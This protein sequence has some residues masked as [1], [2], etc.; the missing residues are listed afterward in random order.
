[1]LDSVQLRLMMGPFV[2][3]TPPRAVM[4]ALDTVEVTVKERGHQWFQLTFLID[5]Q[6][7]LQILFLLTGGLPLLFMRVVLVATVNGV[8][9]V[10]IDGVIT[11]HSIAPGDKG[12]NSTLTI[13]GEDLTALMNQSDWS[14]FPF[15]ACP[16]EARVALIIAKYAMFGVIPLIVPS[17]L[18]DVPLPIDQIPSQQGTALDYIH[19]LADRVG[20]VFYLNARL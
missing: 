17:V 2:P 15:P 16:A 4:D 18:I 19:A 8:R 14:G 7:S 11:N 3:L 12:S 6:S 20:Y 10:L 13:T 5:K 1:M 9:N